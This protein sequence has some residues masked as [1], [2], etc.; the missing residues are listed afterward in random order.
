MGELM[1]DIQFLP[2]VG[3]KR[4]AL[5]KSELEVHTFGELI[6]FYPFRYIDRGSY[7]KIAEI[8][9]D[10]AYVQ[11]IAKIL[12]VT[13]YGPSSSVFYQAGLSGVEKNSFPVDSKGLQA[14]RFNAVKRMSVI[15]SDGTGEME[16]VFFK[17]VKWNFTKMVPGQSFLF[18]GKP[19]A[20]NGKINIVHPDVDP[21]PQD[22]GRQGG[23]TLTGVYTSTEKLK[24]GGITAKAMTKMMAAALNAALPEV[25]ETI[26][27]YIMKQMG[28][29]PLRY[30]LKN[31]HFPQDMNALA[32][33]QHRLKF[34]ELFFL[35]MSLLK[36]EVV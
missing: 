35:Q 21:V 19:Q 3:P 22:A 8:E 23:S 5:L 33:A 12:K 26:P 11:I 1:S 29:V 16:M 2:G 4:A 28:L 9:A 31:I 30:A 7:Q 6:H 10:A 24:N 27:D 32:K 17:G 13:L 34:E 18:F 36:H 14:I 20:F 25:Q 15:V